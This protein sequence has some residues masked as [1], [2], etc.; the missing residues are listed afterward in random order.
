MEDN[1]AA[2]EEIR[3]KAGQLDVVIANAGASYVLGRGARA[4]ERF[5]GIAQYQG[6]IV[7]TPVEQYKAHSDVKTIAPIVLF[8]AA[9]SLLI[10]SPSAKPQFSVISSVVGSI[11]LG[12]SMQAAA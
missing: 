5:A 12:M 10:K 6:P 1:K 3:T 7:S 8:Q 4:D 9:H 2:I 11:S